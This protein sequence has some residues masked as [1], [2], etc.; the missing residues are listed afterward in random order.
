MG[1]FGKSSHVV[2]RVGRTSPRIE[3]GN[4]DPASFKIQRFLTI[5]RYTAVQ[6]RYPTCTNYQGQKILVYE[7]PREQ[8]EGRKTLDPHFGDKG[9]LAPVARFEPTDKGWN[10]ARKFMEALTPNVWDRLVEEG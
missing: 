5:G 3:I 2:Q 10:L 9:D 6:V 1:V 7:V 4:P 8:L